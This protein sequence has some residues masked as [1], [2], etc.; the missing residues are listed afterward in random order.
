M[1]N[2]EIEIERDREVGQKDTKIN[3]SKQRQRDL[4]RKREKL[5]E[6]KK[7]QI[8]REIERH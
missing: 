6:R 1:E 3:R 7:Y 4:D 8:L 5:R 2:T